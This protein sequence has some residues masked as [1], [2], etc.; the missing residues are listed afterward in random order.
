MAATREHENDFRHLVPINRLAVDAQQRLR[1]SATIKSLAVGQAIFVRNADDGLVHY[2]LAGE[3][4]LLENGRLVQRVLASQRIARRPLTAAGPN[5]YTA[6]TV[7]PC[8]V[9][10]ISRVELERVTEASRLSGAAQDLAASELAASP[11]PDWMSR[12]MDSA[13]F[14]VLPNDTIQQLFGALEALEMHAGDFVLRQDDPGE[15]FYVLEDGYCEVNRRAGGGRQEVHVVDLRPGDTFGEAAVIS[16]QPRDASVVALTD[17]RLLRLSKVDFDRLIRAPLVHGIATTEALAATRE[18]ARWLDIGDPE[19]YAKAPLHNSR[20]I[21]LNALRMQATRLARD[22]TYIVCCDEPSLSAVGAYILAER[23]LKVRY[24]E[25]SIVM[26]LT[27]DTALGPPLP[28]RVL[29]NNVVSFPAPHAGSTNEFSRSPANF[30]GIAMD[31]PHL[32]N[33]PVENT[34]ER[35]DRLYTQQ[36]F[37][38]AKSQHPLPPAAY[39]DTHTGQTLARLLEDI[40]ARKEAIEQETTGGLDDAQEFG[41]DDSGSE[42]I[43]LGALEAAAGTGSSRPAPM[44]AVAPATLAV[45]PVAEMV[46]DLEHRVRNYVEANL[47]ERSLETE[48]RYQ[49]KIKHL[50][51]QAQVALRKR[52]A[53]L[54]QRYATHY[55]KK[56]QV[57]RENYQ[58]LMTLATKISQQKAQL[59]AT[60]KQME[61]KLQAANA[62]YKQVEDMRRLLGEN[63]GTLDSL[64]STA[65]S[66]FSV[67]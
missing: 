25:Q 55:A 12:I 31:K 1:A 33:S 5:R 49:E 8:T 61:E 23:G 59:Q 9:L 37:E 44:P 53:D 13:L 64:E 19:V 45:D 63:I 46:H 7:T 36:E 57:L 6:R 43:D 51:Q 34:L 54:K 24:L 20:N 2:L 22:D 35:V 41:F 27:N 38:A 65:G 42:F 32:P 11:P 29:P 39:A 66:R 4:D 60:R 52:D 47:M 50:Q 56:D 67:R 30:R 16:G 48:R 3:L 26:A 58:K 17:V 18:G 62:V 28:T 10:T 15:Y 40:D 21:P 14:Q